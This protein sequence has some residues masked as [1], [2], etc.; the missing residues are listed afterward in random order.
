MSKKLRELQAKKS[1]AATDK[2][3]HLKSASA[4]L[5]KAAAE[6]R[7]LTEVEQGE[8]D[9][10]KA[11][12]DQKTAEIDRLQGQID[13]EQELA[14]ANANANGVVV[15]EGNGNVA[16]TENRAADPKLGFR[17]AGDF[18]QSVRGAT[19]S[20]STGASIDNRLMAAAP[21]TFAGEGVG[22]DGGFLVPPE[23]SKEIF[24]LSLGD[25]SLLPYVDE[26]QIES[27]SMTF[28][29]DET[30]PWGSNGIRAYWQGEAAAA[31]ATKP[32]LGADTLRLKKLMALVP[33]SDE[34]L[35]DASALSSYLPSKIG[36]SIRWKTNE[37]IL[38]GAGG[39]LPS[40]A[41]TSGAALTVTKDSGQATGTLTA[42]NLANMIARLPEGSY[43]RAVWIINNDVLPALFTL[44]LGNYPIYLPAGVAPGA[45]QQNPYGTL[46]GRP[47]IVS[48]HA[49]SFSSAGDVTLVDL[50][51]YQAITKA[52]GIETATSMHLYFDADATAFRTT[53]RFDGQS[54]IAAAIDPANGSNKLS[55][56]VQLGAR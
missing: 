48:Q 30:T 2:A 44:T 39:A 53:F 37:A 56:F 29:R 51:Y 33:V 52:G 19:M 8:F 23:F 16:V 34:L 18:F 13:I 25:A 42:S 43:P 24:Q 20:R 14:V 11:S 49:K 12:A 40:G 1:A 32:V 7:D 3:N 27:N 41:L 15:I 17:S 47:V 28:P 21:S 26:V 35:S 46:L 22:A 54:K 6:N 9:K 5:E 38:F 4:L 45:I 36:A 50:N 55:P 31:T 10:F